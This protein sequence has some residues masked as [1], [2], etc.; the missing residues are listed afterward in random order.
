[1]GFSELRLAV[2]EAGN[3][4]PLAPRRRHGVI[5][6]IDLEEDEQARLNLIAALQAL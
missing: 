2:P 4:L 3:G 1:M 5:E 6:L